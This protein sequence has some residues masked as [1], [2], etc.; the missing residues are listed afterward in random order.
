MC[1]MVSLKMAGNAKYSRKKGINEANHIHRKKP[2][3]NEN[4]NLII[5]PYYFK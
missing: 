2:N 3:T 4:I 5:N 1:R